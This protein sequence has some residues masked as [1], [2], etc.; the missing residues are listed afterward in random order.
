MTADERLDRYAQLAIGV[1]VNLQPGQRLGIN[2]SLEHAPFAR[3]V[4]AHAYAAGALFV[5]VA[6]NDPWLRRSHV[7]HVADD[8]LGWSPPWRVQRIEGL[9]DG[10][11]FLSVVGAPDP[12][13][14]DGLD[15]A[16][17]ARSRQRELSEAH[18]R[19]TDGGCNWCVIGFPNEGWATTVFGAPEL[20][21][22]WQ[23]VAIATRLDQPDPDAAWREHAAVL[24]ARAAR[25]DELAFDELHYRG[26]GTDLRVGLLPGALWMAAYE[27]SGGIRHLANI[28]T[29]EV[30]TTPDA[31]RV[32]CPLRA[33]PRRRGQRGRGRGARTRARR[34]RRGGGTPGRGRAGR[35]R[36]PGR[37]HRGRL[38]RDVVR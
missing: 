19:M 22:L 37:Q 1:G 6:Y 21:R 38:L 11:A 29:E 12:S 30:F 24:E 20:E 28:P 35:P 2:C 25:L 26:P 15:G 10:G 27:E 33:G 16:R 13:V 34:N 9:R 7:S 8:D 17:V 23:A 5:D 31:R 32:S 4:A 18:L 3:A 14:F 36:L